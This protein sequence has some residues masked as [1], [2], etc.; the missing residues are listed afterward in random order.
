MSD[1]EDTPQDA[2]LPPRIQPELTGDLG[3][4]LLALVTAELLWRMQHTPGDLKAADF[5]MI[6]KLLSDNSITLASIRRGDFGHVA[7]EAA[8]SFPFEDGN[9]VV[10]IRDFGGRA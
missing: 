9:R 1:E 7:Q 6:R 8:E 2:Q 10:D 4:D 5:E 3:R